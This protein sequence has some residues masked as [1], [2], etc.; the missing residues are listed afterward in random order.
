[1]IRLSLDSLT[2]WIT[3][4][5]NSSVKF[6]GGSFNFPSSESDGD[7]KLLELLLLLELLE[8]ELEDELYSL[9]TFYCSFLTLK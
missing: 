9:P 2:P 1:M 4:A 6:G 3:V 8:D 5:S 7:G